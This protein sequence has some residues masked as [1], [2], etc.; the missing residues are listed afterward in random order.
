M[1]P[2]NAKKCLGQIPTMK[3]LDVWD[4]SQR[5]FILQVALLFILFHCFTLQCITLHCIS[6]NAF[7][8]IEFASVLHSATTFGQRC[9]HTLSY[10]TGQSLNLFV[11]TYYNYSYFMLTFLSF[12]FNHFKFTFVSTEYKERISELQTTANLLQ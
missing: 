3:Y 7:Y 2:K 12:M 10:C 4:P 5:C 11:L 8:L 1:A 6:L 9:S